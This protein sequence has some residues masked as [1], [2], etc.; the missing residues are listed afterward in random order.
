MKPES[1][2]FAEQ[3]RIVLVR[4]SRMLAGELAE[5]AG[6]AAYIASFHCAQ[7]YIFEANGKV[8]KTHHGVRT[9]F[10]RVTRGD[11]RVDKALQRFLAHSYRLKSIADYFSEPELEVTLEEARTAVETA[12]RFVD[13]FVGL[14]TGP[15]RP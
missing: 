3:A 4:A 6:R 9:E 7:A 2:R 1:A 15:D 11:H 5:D 8:M 13:H 14:L 10:F 12:R